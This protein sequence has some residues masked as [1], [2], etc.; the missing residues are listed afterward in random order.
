MSLPIL[1]ILLIVSLIAS[2][3]FIFNKSATQ[4]SIQR[5]ALFFAF[6]ISA[7]CLSATFVFFQSPE[8]GL[9][10]IESYNWIG[11]ILVFKLGLDGLSV[12]MLILIGFIL[13]IIVASQKITISK[14]NY[15]LLFAF[16]SSVLGVF[17]AQDL[18][19]FFI[20]FELEIIPLYFPELR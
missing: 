11:N 6:I 9:Q 3:S 2:F 7:L 19:S 20:L 18:I 8:T 17:I 13:P 4:K 14:L 16:I 15:G 1:S 12:N 10:L 5:Q